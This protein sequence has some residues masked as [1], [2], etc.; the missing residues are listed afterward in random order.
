MC[1]RGARAKIFGE[2]S[3]PS[4]AAR[5]G[6]RLQADPANHGLFLYSYSCARAALYSYSWPPAGLYSY[7]IS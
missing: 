2:F 4:P 3:A 7:L 1:A 5:R 6:E